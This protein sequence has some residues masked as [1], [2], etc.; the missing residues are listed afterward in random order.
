MLTLINTVREK[1][2]SLSGISKEHVSTRQ[3]NKTVFIGAFRFWIVM[4]CFFVLSDAE[5]GTR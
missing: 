3:G 5:G 2:T 4:H 1:E